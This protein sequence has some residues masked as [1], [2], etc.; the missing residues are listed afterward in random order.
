MASQP[1]H[2][3]T[4]DEYLRIDSNA[5]LRSEFFYGEMFDMAGSSVNH[6]LI[7]RNLLLAV[8]AQLAGKDCQAIHSDLRLCVDTESHYTY[9]DMMVVCGE[10]QVMPGR[11]DTILN[12]AA[13]FEVLS[14]STAAHDRGAKFHSYQRIPTLREYFL[15]SQD[16]IF[17][18]RFERQSDGKWL[19]S[20]HEGPDAVLPIV[21]AGCAVSLAEIYSGI[22]FEV[23]A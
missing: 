10:L 14:K 6:V 17:G 5:A 19:L 7:A 3:L 4:S 12:P 13:I 22:R 16:R 9:P 21:S 2:L 15:L 18:E 8:S 20:N 11:N 23:S 1:K